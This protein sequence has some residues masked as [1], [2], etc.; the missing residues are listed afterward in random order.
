MGKTTL[1]RVLEA[2]LR[3]PYQVVG[4]PYARLAPDE[5]WSFVLHQ[6]GAPR[7]SAPEREVLAIATRLGK[8]GHTL[9]LLVDDANT[10]PEA[11][12]E[13]LAATLTEGA[14]ALRA[15]LTAD[16]E[17]LVSGLPRFADA[18]VLRVDE[19]LSP[20]ETEAYLLGRLLH[21]ASPV[22]VR[23]R[24]DPQTLAALHRDSRGLPGELNR[25]AGEIERQ[26]L[27]PPV[28][29]PSSPRAPAPEEPPSPPAPLPRAER[30][31]GSPPAPTGW[32]ATALGLLPHIGLG[33]GI[34]LALLALWLWLAPLFSDR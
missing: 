11:T 18:A 7:S 34:P 24:F 25:L 19:P 28:P 4:L 1:L 22:A 23:R 9:V 15:V 27:A 10:L 16:D 21:F 14:G 29:P 33:L 31:P 26:A 5:F 8:L 2:R 17:A 6:L 12:G 13:S 20:A 3:D 30:S 32:L